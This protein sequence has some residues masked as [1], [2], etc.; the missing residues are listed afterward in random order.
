MSEF[1]TPHG[2]HLGRRSLV[3][4]VGAVGVA[5]VAGGALAACTSDERSDSGAATSGGE[6]APEPTI[7][8]SVA[9]DEQV[10]VDHL[11]RVEAQGGRLAAVTVTTAEGT[12]VP[13]EMLEDGLSW[14]A[15]ALLD[16]GTTYSL[17]ASARGEGGGEA[18]AEVSFSTVELS[19]D[20][21]TYPSIAPLADEEVGVGMPVVV[22]FDLPVVDRASFERHMSVTSEPAQPGSWH[23]YDDHQ[24]RWRP[25]TYWQPGTT[26]TVDVAV[27]GVP[28]GGGIY[29]QESRTVTFRVGRSVIHRV[30]AA[31]HTMTTLIDGVEARRMPI[32]AGK[33]GFE[34][35]SGVKV[36]MEKFRTKTMDAATTGISP[37][38]PEY[39]NIEDVEYALRVTNSGEFLHAAP[40][41]SGSQGVANVSHGCVG[42]AT[43]D[44]A[45]VY[46]NT[47]RGDVVEVTG[48]DR[49]M[50]LEN[51]FG[52]WNATPE[53]YAAGSAL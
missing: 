12:E 50:T 10:P 48:T 6:S 45:W 44:A 43:P 9:A 8:T 25:D 14:A 47:R 18:T 46:E 38:D 22:A 27:N 3:R 31:T 35:R 13:G 20:E 2:V 36:V 33:P 7:V 23:W 1:R 52:D 17:R 32:S 39:Y 28:A 49:R 26:V 37:D 34:T 53:E 24:V 16:P 40:W 15:T 11:V 30:D 42:M 5:A 41:S 51:G 29:G 4:I 19:L 21:Q